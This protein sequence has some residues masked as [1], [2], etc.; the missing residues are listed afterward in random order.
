MANAFKF[1]V[2][3]LGILL[4]RKERRE[5]I[6]QPPYR[7]AA[8]SRR[9][10]AA[11]GRWLRNGCLGGGGAALLVGMTLPKANLWKIRALTAGVTAALVGLVIIVVERFF[12]WDRY[13]EKKLPALRK[14]LLS[15][16]FAQILREYELDAVE[17]HNL[18]P[19]AVLRAKLRGELIVGRPSYFEWVDREGDVWV[20]RGLLDRPVL[21]AVRRF[22]H[23]MP[24]PAELGARWG[25][26]Q[27]EL[28]NL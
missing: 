16:S 24:Q 12:R 10:D 9:I 14:E 18:V 8:E 20:E 28:A 15:R 22:T 11:C 2:D 7:S 26:L 6:G 4:D 1:G 19:Q 21:E 3:C 17:R 25:Q 23:S 5:A 13:A 27:V